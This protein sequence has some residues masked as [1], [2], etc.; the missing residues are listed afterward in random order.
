MSKNPALAERA[1]LSNLSF[2]WFYSFIAQAQLPVLADSR[3]HFDSNRL[4]SISSVANYG[5]LCSF[6]SPLSWVTK[7]TDP[8]TVV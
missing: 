3:L 8:R 4:N 7:T 2:N 1:C 6:L 5:L